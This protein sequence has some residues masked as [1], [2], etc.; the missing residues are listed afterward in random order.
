MSSK[1]TLVL[2]ILVAFILVQTLY[3]K[4]SAHPD[5]VHIFE[6]VGMEP[7]GRIGIGILELIAAV[8]LLIPKTVWLGAALALGI[9]SGAVMMHLT[10]LGIDV[11][12][13]GGKLFYM[14]VFVMLNSAYILWKKRQDA[15]DFLASLRA[16]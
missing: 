9:I 7:W 14:A 4:F 5:S 1:F 2:R 11:Q 15:F 3:Y 12:G 10:L 8:L 16:K 6:T 13:D